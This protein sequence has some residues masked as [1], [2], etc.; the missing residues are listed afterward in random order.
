MAVYPGENMQE[1]EANPEVDNFVNRPG[2]G[3]GRI[4]RTCISSGSLEPS[5]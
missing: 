2:R 4:F 5:T 1:A 3:S